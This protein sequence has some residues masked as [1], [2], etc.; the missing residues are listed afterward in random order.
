MFNRC[1]SLTTAPELPATT[2]TEHCYEGMFIGCTSL[3]TAPEL[4]STTLAQSCYQGM[5]NGC[6][7]LT[8]AP[9]L[10]A[11]TLAGS[12]YS[13]MFN[14]CRSLTKAPDL[15]STTLA[16]ECYAWMFSNCTSLTTA[17]ELPATTLVVYSYSYM[18]YGCGLLTNVTIIQ[19]LPSE[20]FVNCFNNNT[21]IYITSPNASSIDSNAFVNISE[22]GNLFLVSGSKWI[23][24]DNLLNQFVGWKL[25][26]D[27][28]Y[29]GIIEKGTNGYYYDEY[30]DYG[31]TTDDT[32]LPPTDDT[33]LPPITDT[34]VPGNPN[35]GDGTTYNSLSDFFE[36]A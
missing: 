15:P 27:N 18:F 16:N 10:P 36:N 14:G 24:D 11:T 25:Y 29:I 33:T 2:L 3:T 5:F 8:T 34:T 1:T 22:T 26:I 17:P 35:N 21:N 13:S 23:T 31:G 32:T 20:T 6:S 28:I 12:C 30:D 9:E 4:P 7:S 19:S